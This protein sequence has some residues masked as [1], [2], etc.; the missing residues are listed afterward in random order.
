MPNQV[1]IF[2]PRSM[3]CALLLIV[4]CSISIPQ[5][6]AAE[7]EES[8]TF[9]ISSFEVEGNH[10][11]EAATIDSVL[12]PF[13]GEN[14]S[15]ATVQEAL[16]ALE[17]AYAKIGYSTVLV[18]LPE[19]R[20]QEGMVKFKV[21]E[22][23]V[24]RIE[25]DKKRYFDEEN[26]VF[27]LPSLKIGETPNIDE[28]SANLAQVGS[29]PAKRLNVVFKPGEEE[30]DVVANVKIS[31]KNPIRWA[32]TLDTTGAHRTGLF[33]AGI[34]YQNSNMFNM[35]HVLT[36]QVIT[37]PDKH[38]KDVKIGAISY[39]IPFY[40]WNS[41][42]D[43]IVAYSSV[44]S[45]GISTSVGNFNVQGAGSVY[46]VHYTQNIDRWGDWEPKASLGFSYRVFKTHVE[47]IN[48]VQNLVPPVTIHPVDLTLSLSKSTEPHFF[49]GYLSLVQ[50]I[51]FGS[52]GTTD[53]F[54]QIGL[55]P[56]SRASYFLARYGADYSYLFK[57]GWQVRGRLNGQ[58]TRDMLMSGE[59]FGMGGHDS[60]RGLDE[61]ALSNDTGNQVTFE[62]YTPDFGKYVTDYLTFLPENFRVR[63][64]T[65]WDA[66]TVKRNHP[67]VFESQGS[68]A[69]SAGFGLRAAFGE[70][71]DFSI[72]WAHIAH[73]EDGIAHTKTHAQLSWTF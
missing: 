55:R 31:E 53:T 35:D 72:D 36:M 44:N 67:D 70:N 73:P 57:S 69:Q 10:L 60:I 13:V 40:E 64:L 30:G 15:F 18:T 43:A 26:V 56:H 63:A 37:S 50:N 39:H 38:L 24:A 45:G 9:T 34:A 12:A 2:S 68:H 42:V 4:C 65:F 58:F 28:M 23:R 22:G 66:G 21:V 41:S 48:T 27:S 5:V 6:F 25:F 46:E 1:K 8:L 54:A 3:L 14:K 7:T 52:L 49:N 71:V 47:L 59:Q 20:L 61:R 33:R 17:Q 16:E 19:Q 29:S 62:A 32:A 11:L 51:P